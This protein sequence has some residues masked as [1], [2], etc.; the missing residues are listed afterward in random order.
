MHIWQCIKNDLKRIFLVFFIVQSFNEN[1][2][3]KRVKFRSMY[4]KTDNK[5]VVECLS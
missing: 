2:L 3:K 5:I 4:A 1:T